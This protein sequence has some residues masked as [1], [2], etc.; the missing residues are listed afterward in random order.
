MGL[1]DGSTDGGRPGSPLGVSLGRSSPDASLLDL[2]EVNLPH[3]PRCTGWLAGVLAG[4]RGNVSRWPDRG[5]R[6]NIAGF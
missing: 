5:R 1:M 6:G 2:H 4:R 3:W